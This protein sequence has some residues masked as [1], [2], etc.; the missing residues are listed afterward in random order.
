MCSN[1]YFGVE[2]IILVYECNE[3]KKWPQSQELLAEKC[4]IFTK[5][6]T[7]I[8]TKSVSFHQA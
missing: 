3:F 6:F 1:K 4:G 2:Y 8:S 7:I 5:L